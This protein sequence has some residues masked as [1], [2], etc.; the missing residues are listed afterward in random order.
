MLR[1]VTIRDL[2]LKGKAIWRALR[3]GEHAVVTSNGE[4][5]ALLVGIDG[6]NL[7]ETLQ[8]IHQAQALLAVGRMTEHARQRG[9]DR[10]GLDEIEAVIEESRR[11]RNR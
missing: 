7:D 10:L 4:P 8:V 5:Q 6:D 9:L 11:E 3:K 1:F 2:R